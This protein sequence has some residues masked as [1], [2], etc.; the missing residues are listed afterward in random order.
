MLTFFRR[1]RKGLLD[2]GRTSKYLLYAIGEI[3]LVMIGILLALQVNNWNEWRKDRLLEQ[4]ILEDL[5]NNLEL[6]CDILNEYISNY[7]YY[8]RSSEVILSFIDSN[9]PYSDTLQ[10]HFHNARVVLFQSFIPRTGYESLKDAGLSILRSNL[11]VNEIQNLF[12]STYPSMQE[13]VNQG[14][15]NKD[16]WD[17][18][19]SQHFIFDD[20]IYAV[21]RLSPI[22][23]NQIKKSNYFNHQTKFHEGWRGWCIELQEE[24][25]SETQRVLQLIRDEL[26]ESS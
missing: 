16:H 1:I 7:R 2:G 23:I 22:D 25:L 21:G 4:E 14:K 10:T 9:L 13:L 15:V 3:A 20:S 18:Y 17:T 24:C 19:I 8:N 5:V 26:G 11:I 6:N 12:E